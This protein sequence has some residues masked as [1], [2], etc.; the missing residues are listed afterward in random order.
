M[1]TLSRSQLISVLESI[2]L[3]PGDHLLVHSAVQ[4]L[5]R[6]EGGTGMYF[7]ALGSVL[8]LVRDDGEFLERQST[9]THRSPTRSTI[10]VPTFTFTFAHDDPFD[11]RS[12]PSQGMGTFSEYVRKQPGAR[13]TPHPMQSLAVIGYYAS[14][15]ARRDTLSAFDPGSAFERMLELDFKLLLLGADI[16]SVSLVHYSEQRAHV[17]YRYWKDF[18]GL[19]RIY[20]S[21]EEETDGQWETR[22]Y[23]MF[24][25]D[26]E[27]DPRLNLLPIQAALQIRGQWSSQHLNYGSLSLCR[28]TDFVDATDQLLAADPWALVSSVPKGISK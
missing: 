3:C 15:M 21:D 2:G 18:T 28:V 14:D 11:L 6:L 5:G 19:V 26:L 20:P 24:A 17:P 25:R 23:R 1:Q 10:A 16:Q 8:G 4:F 13:R 9:V 22:T 27:I 7:E 12:T